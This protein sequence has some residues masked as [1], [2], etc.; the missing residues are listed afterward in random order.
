MKRPATPLRSQLPDS[1]NERLDFS[2]PAALALPTIQCA[3]NFHLKSFYSFRIGTKRLRIT[4]P[5]QHPLSNN[6]IK[7]K[8]R[9]KKIKRREN[10]KK[11]LNINS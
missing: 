8:G 7:Q 11:T 6:Y 1:T 9:K 4:L 3:L 10:K 5:S 2:P